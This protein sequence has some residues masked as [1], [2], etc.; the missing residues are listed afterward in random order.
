MSRKQPLPAVDE[1]ALA[2][3]A[4]QFPSGFPRPAE[5]PA[6]QTVPPPAPAGGEKAADAPPA[7][8]MPGAPPRKARGRGL[9][10][11]ALLVALLALVVSAALALPP[12]ARAWLASRLDGY[13]V[14]GYRIA[15]L[16][17]GNGA[18]IDARL[19]AATRS[20]DALAG[21]QAEITARLAA[22]ETVIGSGA[23]MRRLDSVEAG[24][25]A[26]R[27]QLAASGDADRLAANRAASVETK[28]ASVEDNVKAIQD[29]LAADERDVNGM[30]TTRLGAVEADVGALQKVDRRP[31]KFF[32]AA[33]QLRDRVRGAGPFAH[34]L[35]AAQSLAGPNPE[36]AAALKVLDGNAKHGVATVAELRNEFF[37]VLEPRLAAV[38]AVNRQPVAERAWGW[39]RSWF[40]TAGA[41]AA[42][43]DRNAALVRMA[44]RSLD[45]GQIEPAVHQLLLLEDEAALVAAEWLKNASARLA[46]DKAVATIMSQALDQIAATK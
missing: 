44:A 37:T 3:L 39:V 11:F 2:E 36:I 24:L 16:V 40:A 17:A 33:L 26:V 29:K 8:A 19:A 9:A 32:L 25:G 31:E 34:E 23:A 7:A 15:D 45:Q 42:A 13:R 4:G 20:V 28:L 46:A 18:E 43:D 1:A 30:L 22:V 10:A 21:R 35:A 12:P 27:Q 6:P 5:P 38:A 41:G 14:G